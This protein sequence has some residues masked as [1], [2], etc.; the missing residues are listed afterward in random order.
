MPIQHFDSTINMLRKVLDLRSKNQQIISSNIANA[1]TPGYTPSS[2][3][4]E[5][6]LRSAV[7]GSELKPVATR[8]GHIPA[9]PADLSRVQ[10]TITTHPDR[11]GIGDENGVSVDKE[12]IKLSENQILY[13]AAIA[14][15]NK[16][17]SILKYAAN[18]GR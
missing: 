9:N 1:D 15:L 8:P 4:F 2:L 6:Q 7:S 17:L 16:K 12:M 3:E 5:D 14:M 18:D 10:G 13:E 11:T